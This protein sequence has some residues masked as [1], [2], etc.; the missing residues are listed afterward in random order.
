MKSKEITIKT[1]NRIIKITDEVI[2]I[3]DLDEF[4]LLEVYPDKIK[5][6]KETK[7]KIS[8]F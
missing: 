5:I 3:E 4:P 2:R 8:R 7:I 1:K 6:K